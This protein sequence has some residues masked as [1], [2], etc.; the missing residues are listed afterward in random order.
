MNRHGDVRVTCFKFKLSCNVCHCLLFGC[1]YDATA[2]SES[3][4]CISCL[5]HL[6][7]SPCNRARLSSAVPCVLAC[8]IRYGPGAAQPTECFCELALRLFKFKL[9]VSS[10]LL[11]P[12]L[13]D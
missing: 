4:Q 1:V 13:Q 8:F 5:V 12:L 3:L 6:L 2:S 10:L 9:A 7:T 11:A